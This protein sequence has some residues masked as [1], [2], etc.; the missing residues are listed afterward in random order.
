MEAGLKNASIA[1]SDEV[2]GPQV[3]PA[4]GGGSAVTAPAMAND[5]PKRPMTSRPIQKPIRRAS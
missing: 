4:A 2:L 1:V 5:T 3:P